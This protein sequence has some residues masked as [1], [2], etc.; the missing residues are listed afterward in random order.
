MELLSPV[1]LGQ[2]VASE[3]CECSRLYDAKEI[4]LDEC[5][6]GEQMCAEVNGQS[7]RSSTSLLLAQIV[8]PLKLASGL[9]RQSHQMSSC[10]L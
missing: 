8:S 1:Y 7:V 10:G 9:T 5:F 6:A 2:A 3:G 4:P